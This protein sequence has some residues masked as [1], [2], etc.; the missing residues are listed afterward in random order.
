MV[1]SLEDLLRE[2]FAEELDLDESKKAITE[3]IEVY[4]EE[5]PLVTS[6][7]IIC[8][9]R[10]IN[11]EGYKVKNLSRPGGYYSSLRPEKNEYIKNSKIIKL[12]HIGEAIALASKL[13]PR[14]KITVNFLGQNRR[15]T[16]RINVFYKDETLLINYIIKRTRLVE[17]TYSY[18]FIDK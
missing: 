12:S 16:K 7:E 3:V 13:N 10:N 5:C 17:V 1:K 11:D 9:I 14:D 18:E 2:K 6:S 4:L 15:G 8:A